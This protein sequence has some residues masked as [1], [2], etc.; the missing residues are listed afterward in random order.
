VN[1][2]VVMNLALAINLLPAFLHFLVAV[3]Q[4]LFWVTNLFS[5]FLQLL[6]LAHQ[7]SKNLL[8]LHV[9]LSRHLAFFFV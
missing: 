5:I 8:D 2:K 9:K 4:N 3:H 7:G 6:L 1:Q